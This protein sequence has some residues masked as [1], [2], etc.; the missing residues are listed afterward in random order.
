MG[1]KMLNKFLKRHIPQV[2]KQ[3]PFSEY[4]NKKIAIDVNLYLYYFKCLN[5]DDWL[6]RFYYMITTFN[7]YNIHCI[8]IYDTRAPKEKF[9]K[10]QDRKQRKNNA[11]GKIETI[12]AD[13]ELFEQ[14]N[15]TSDLLN[16][17]MKKYSHRMLVPTINKDVIMSEIKRLEIQTIGISYEEILSSKRLLGLMNISYVDSNTEAETLCSYMC[18]YNQ[19][20]AVLSNDTDVLAYGAP[21]FI[22]QLNLNNE[23]FVEVKFEEILSTLDFTKDQ[24]LDFCI[25]CGTDYNKNIYRIGVENAFKY[26]KKFISIEEALK[27][28]NKKYP[29]SDSGV[30]NYVRVR[31][32]FSIPE[33]LPTYHINDITPVDFLKIQN[34]FR[35]LKEKNNLL[36]NNS[37]K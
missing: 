15:E 23:T 28:I 19:V 37:Q 6:N 26:I 36:Q 25:M 34:F 21:R 5:G 14:N 3:V 32:I 9:V 12:K 31:E 10:Q 29:K 11:K 18:V 27:E 7:R 24:F 2:F 20:D 30:L 13:L 8:Y 33:E 17:I 16:N 35:E 4:T 1:I 22:T